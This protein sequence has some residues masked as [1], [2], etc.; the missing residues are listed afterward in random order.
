MKTAGII[1]E[2]NPFHNGHRYQ[3][4]EL[5]ARTGADYIIIAMS[6]DF[7]QRGEPAIFDK[8]TRTR[9][10]LNAGADLVLELPAA[11]ATSSAE[12]FAACG[13]ALLDKLGVVDMLCFGSECGDVAALEPVARLLAEEPEEYGKLLRER[14]SQGDSFPKAREWAVTEWMKMETSLLSSPNNILGIEYMKAL[15]RRGS[16]IKPYT[17]QRSGQ[18]YNDSDFAAVSVTDGQVFASASAIRNALRDKAVSDAVRAQIPGSIADDLTSLTPVFP[19]DLSALL[20]FRLLDLTSSGR[21]LTDF[22]D[23]SPEL[24]DRIQN[25]LLETASYTGRIEQLKTRQYTYTRISRALLH[26]L[27]GT[28]TNQIQDYRADDYVSY[29]RILGFRKSTAPLLSEIKKSSQIPLISKVADAEKI[30]TE[31]SWSDSMALHSFRYDLHC[32]HVYQSVVYQKSGVLPR[33]EYTQPIV[34]V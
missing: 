16:S 31:S 12:D 34:I 9:M 14:M 10:A 19:D 15:I 21:N 30:L 6:G 8:Y 17:I 27:L 33:N 32:S 11:F 29:A 25:R 2:Y 1:A 28:T 26:I 4:E 7:V 23:V 3:L 5:R 18:G 20:N 22:S 13:V 24:A